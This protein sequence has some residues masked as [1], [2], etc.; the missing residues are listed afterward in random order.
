MRIVLFRGFTIPFYRFYI[1]NGNA[2]SEVITISKFILCIRIALF[3][4]FTI[5]FHRFYR[6]NGNSFT[7]FITNSKIK[8]CIRIALFCGFAIP[9]YRFYIINGNAIS[10]V[11]TISKFAL[12]FHMP[13]FRSFATPYYSFDTINGNSIT[14]LVKNTK[15]KLGV[16]I[17]T[18]CK[19][20]VVKKYPSIP[21]ICLS[22][23]N[24]NALAIT[25]TKSQ[26]FHCINV[27][28][29]CRFAIPFYGFSFIFRHT[30]TIGITIS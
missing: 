12:C 11:I 27:S 22:I 16:C 15:L 2:I 14:K 17:S 3:R 26:S 4:S 6:I 29:I 19:I 24:S 28:L 7:E 1:I 8:L 23:V 18:L 13:L 20:L 10:E 30:K 5:P 25:I 9:F 21:F